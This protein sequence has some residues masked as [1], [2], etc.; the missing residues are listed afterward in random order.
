MV[1][2]LVIK[3][4]IWVW[5]FDHSLWP[6]LTAYFQISATNVYLFLCVY[7]LH[8]SGLLRMTQMQVKN[9]LTGAV[10]M[11]WLRSSLHAPSQSVWTDRAV[12]LWVSTSVTGPASAAEMP[13]CQHVWW[14]WFLFIYFLYLHLTFLLTHIFMVFSTHQQAL[15]RVSLGQGVSDSCIWIRSSSY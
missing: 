1:S 6:N 14:V 8:L 2:E 12:S 9:T 15:E 13:G 11:V 10:S 7:W 4:K 3:N 5:I